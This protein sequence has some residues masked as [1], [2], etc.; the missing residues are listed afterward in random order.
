MFWTFQDDRHW[1]TRSENLRDST[2][3]T[4]VIVGVSLILLVYTI[5]Y[6]FTKHVQFFTTERIIF[7]CQEVSSDL[8]LRGV[9]LLIDLECRT[10]KT[11]GNR[12]PPPAIRG[13]MITGFWS[14]T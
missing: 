6:P 11:E 13:E 12:T 10:I 1:K 8:P 9:P 4:S 3:N 7:I 14:V 2:F 5:L